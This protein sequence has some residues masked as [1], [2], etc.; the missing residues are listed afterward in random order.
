MALRGRSARRGIRDQIDLKHSEEARQISD[1]RFEQFF[2]TLPDY[3]YMVSPTGHILDINPAACEALGYAREELVGKP[4]SLIYAPESHKKVLSLLEKWKKTGKITDEEM[5]VVT[6][7]GEK[8]TVLLNV[9]SVLDQHGKLLHSTSVQVDITERKRIEEKLRESQERLA[10]GIAAAMDAVEGYAPAIAA[11][12]KEP[13][14]DDALETQRQKLQSLT[15]RER[16]ILRFLVSGVST[17]RI[18]ELLRVSPSTV[19]NHVQNLFSKLGAHSR[20]ECVAIAH[21][22]GFE[23]EARQQRLSH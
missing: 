15:A 8:R 22:I 17:K 19:R 14:S 16:E 10:A 13:H 23:R 12:A 5:V 2:A 7:Q 6:K 3:C 20:L 1:R 18:S 21:R 11:M 4:L 9:R